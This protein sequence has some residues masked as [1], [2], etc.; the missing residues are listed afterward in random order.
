MGMFD[1]YVPVPGLLCPI[2]RRELTGWQGKN[3]PCALVRWKQGKRLPE[4]TVEEQ[5]RDEAFMARFALPAEFRLYSWCP[6]NHRV[7]A[8]SR[9]E[10]GI[11]TTT[12]IVESRRSPT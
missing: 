6:S 9:S 2:C 3:G 4:E 11:W 12:E 7:D 8:R 1:W 5:A 10:D